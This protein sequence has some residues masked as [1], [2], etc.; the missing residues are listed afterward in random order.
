M[1]AA[2]GFG[3]DFAD[4]TVETLGLSKKIFRPHQVVEIHGSG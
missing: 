3:F 1:K 2:V 4:L